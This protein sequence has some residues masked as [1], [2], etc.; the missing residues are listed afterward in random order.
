MVFGSGLLL[1]MLGKQIRYFCIPAGLEYYA[2][3]KHLAWDAQPDK[4][5]LAASNL[6]K[7]VSEISRELITNGYKKILSS[8]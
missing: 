5:E 3:S 1:G 7:A 8:M 6:G 4:F 2:N